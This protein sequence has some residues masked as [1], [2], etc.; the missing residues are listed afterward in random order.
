MDLKIDKMQATSDSTGVFVI[1]TSGQP[2]LLVAS[3]FKE[4]EQKQ[5]LITPGDTITAVIDFREN[6]KDRF[7]VIFHRKNE[8]NYNAYYDLNKKFDR[9]AIMEMA[10]SAESLEN[11]V[12][13]LDRLYISHVEKIKT[14]LKPSLLRDFMLG[15]EKMYVFSCLDYRLRVAP[16][17][18][19]VSDFL[20]IKN[21][22]FPEEKIVCDN[23]LYMKS[24]PYIGGMGYLRYF[25]C[26]DIKADNQLIATTDTIEKYFDGELKDYLLVR[27]FGSTANL[28]K[29]NKELDGAD[30]DSWYH[31]YIGKFKEDIYNSY[32]QYAYERY[33]ILNNPFTESVLESEISQL[34]DRSVYTIRDFLEKYKGRQLVLDNWASWCGPC[35]FEMQKGA[36]NVQKLK[37]RGNTFVYISIDEIRDFKKAQEKAKEL[38]IIENAYLISGGY[39]SIYAKYMNIVSIPRFIMIDTEGKVKNLAMPF[40]SNIVYFSDYNAP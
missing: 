26:K 13:T 12:Q 6:N 17:E 34:S 23:S 27:N 30:V 4:M 19:S 33:K 35:F 2:N 40:P 32:I 15:E 5:I 36:E 7:E 3:L 20:H 38:G 1:E 25:L 21:R 8:E 11:Y 10:K 24:A 29:K 39:K 31:D 18:L 9:N 22:Y 37:E 14:A 16:E 28:Y